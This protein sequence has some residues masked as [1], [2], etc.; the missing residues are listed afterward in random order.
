MEELEATVRKVL[1]SAVIDDTQKAGSA[2]CTSPNAQR[3]DFEMGRGYTF[4]IGEARTQRTATVIL[5]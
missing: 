4:I 1:V 2:G 5:V 3:V